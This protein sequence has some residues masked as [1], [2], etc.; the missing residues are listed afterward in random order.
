DI[1][2]FTDRGRVF[3]TK[4]YEI[5]AGTRTAKGKPVHNFLEIPTEENVTAIVA[6][7]TGSKGYL[8]MVTKNGLIKK[9]TLD[10]FDN[11]RRTGII[12]INLKGDDSLNWVKLSSGSDEILITTANCQSIR[13]KESQARPMGRTAAGVRAIRLKKDNR[14][15]FMEIISAQFKKQN[16]RLLVVMSNGYGKQTPLSQYRVQGRGGSG[17]KAA[18][19]TSK[20]GQI[21]AAHLVD[22]ETEIL[23]IS[24]KGQ[25]IRTPLASV[26]IAGRA[27]QGVRIMNLNA[28][29]KVTGIVCL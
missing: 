9:T 8:V 23:A 17:I 3:K 21:V 13:F 1:L 20:T 4:V 24:N 5:P 22:E 26:R 16:P 14:V 10:A 27:T 28:G 18:Q 11:I 12:A 2:F 19:V 25:I 6:H 29:D 7:P 15:S